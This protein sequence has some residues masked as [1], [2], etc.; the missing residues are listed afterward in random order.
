[1]SS[2]ISRIFQKRIQNELKLIQKE[3]LEWIDISPD[4]NDIRTWYF[5][6][7]GPDDTHYTGGLYMGKVVLSEN[8]PA[9]PVDFYMLTPNGRFDIEKKICLTISSYHSDQWSSIWNIQKI[10]GAFLSV[11]VSDYDTGISH[12]K[13]SPQERASLAKSSLQ[14]NLNIYPKIF[15]SFKRFVEEKADGSVFIKPMEQVRAE[16]PKPKEKKKKNKDSQEGQ[17]EETKT[18]ANSIDLSKLKFT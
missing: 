12:I 9:T 18:N 16:M 8:Y 3:P 4:E 14:Y 7:R 13:T 2:A 15:K 10:L 6:I 1:M 5:L 11:M 17:E